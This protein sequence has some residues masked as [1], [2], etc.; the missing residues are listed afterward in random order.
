M[1]E[2]SYAGHCGADVILRRKQ[3]IMLSNSDLTL[4]KNSFCPFCELYKGVLGTG[5]E[6]FCSITK[7]KPKISSEKKHFLIK[8]VVLIR[9]RLG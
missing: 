2:E 7:I 9:E 3:K 1:C 5:Y 6:N 4:K 8:K